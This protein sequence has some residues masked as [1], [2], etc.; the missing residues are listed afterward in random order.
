MVLVE[1][2]HQR[3]PGGLIYS[4][5]RVVHVGATYHG[6][7]VGHQCQPGAT[8]TLLMCRSHPDVASAQLEVELEHEA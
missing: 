5:R 1:R 7:A 6:R 8:T 4:R 2:S 3:H